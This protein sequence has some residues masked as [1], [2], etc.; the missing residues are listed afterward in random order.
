MNGVYKTH[1]SGRAGALEEELNEYLR[2]RGKFEHHPSSAIKALR[3][4]AEMSQEELAR[5]SGV[6]RSTIAR[7]EAGDY[8]LSGALAERLAPVF[9]L[10]S[11]VLMTA[12]AMTETQRMAE[13][14]E[15]SPL[16]LLKAIEHLSEMLPDDEASENLITSLLHILKTT[17]ERF[18]REHESGSGR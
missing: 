18:D 2:E 11:A 8:S 5:R 7:M 17:L 10:D 6:G 3:S 9:Y 16:A 4:A 1:L 15:L 14:G 13:R 12:E